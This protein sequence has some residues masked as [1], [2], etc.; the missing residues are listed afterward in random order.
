MNTWTGVA[1]EAL[2]VA[3]RNGNESAF[4]KLCE[5]YWPRLV[6][7]CKRRVRSHDDAEDIVSL[8]FARVLKHTKRFNE[9]RKFSTWIY[10]IAKN[11]CTNFNRDVRRRKNV[12]FDELSENTEDRRGYQFASTDPDQ[13]DQLDLAERK[14][15]VHKAMDSLPSHQRKIIVLRDFDGFPYRTIA[16]IEQMKLGTVKSQINR[17]RTGVV[18]RMEKYFD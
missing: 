1:D 12:S 4:T 8:T 5:K 18:N 3:F 7:F 16:E 10:N 6:N 17:G 14:Q 9:R 11:L 15:A 2:F 13:F